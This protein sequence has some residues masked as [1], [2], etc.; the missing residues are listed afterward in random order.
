MLKR[1]IS[2]LLVAVM[3][4]SLMA[5]CGNEASKEPVATDGVNL[6]VWVT[7]AEDQSETSNYQRYLKS[8]SGFM[9]NNEGYN[10]PA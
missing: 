10:G 1:I 4:V 9:Q 6:E 7:D 2:A 3:A 8:A 5:S